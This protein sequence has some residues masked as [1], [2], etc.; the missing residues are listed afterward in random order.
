MP[1]ILRP[2]IERF[3]EKCAFDPCTGCVMWIGGTTSGRGHSQPYGSFWFEGER[4]FAHRWSARYIHGFDIT[5][6][7]VDHH[8]PCGPSTL[9]VHHVRPEPAEVNRVLQN[10]RPGRA[11]QDLETRQHWLLVSKGVRSISIINNHELP[12]PFYY[13]P[14]WIKHHLPEIRNYG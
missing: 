11:F 3:I 7:Q 8:C 9:C 12:V 10:I 13:P 4:W 5:G 1:K 2:A 6:L 14:E